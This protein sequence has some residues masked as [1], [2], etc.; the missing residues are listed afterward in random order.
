MKYPMLDY[1]NKMELVELLKHIRDSKDPTDKDFREAIVN[2]LK[3][4]K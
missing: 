2:K 1:L 4:M 3:R